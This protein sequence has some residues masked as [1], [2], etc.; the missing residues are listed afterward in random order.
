MKR[1]IISSLTAMVL[2]S[3]YRLGHPPM[4]SSWQPS[5]FLIGLRSAPPAKAEP[6]ALAAQAG[7]NT[8]VDYV[9]PDAL[10]LARRCG[11]KLM[12]AKIGLDPAT[13]RG[14]EGRR[15]AA[16]QVERFGRHP[17]LWGYFLGDEAREAD[18][19][20]L[21]R[22]ADS[23]RQHAK[24]KPFFVSLLPSD[25]FV[26]PALANADYVGYVERF[27]RAVRPPLLAYAYLPLRAGESEGGWFENLEIIRR[28]ALA[29]GIPFCA[30]LRGSVWPGMQPLGE[31][32]L[33][34]QVYTSLAYGAQGVAWFSYWGAPD[35]GR[36]GIVA[37]DGSPTERYRWIAALNA[38]LRTLGPTL[39]RLRSTAVYHT[40][41]VPPGATRLPVHGLVGAIEGG[42]F[43]VGLFD[44]G[45]RGERY[46]LLA[47]QER[48]REVTAKM[49]IHQP[50]RSAAWLDP[51]TGRWLDLAAR[52]DRFQT[53]IEFPLPAGGGRLLRLSLKP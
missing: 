33:R 27:L 18:F 5:E 50:C 48:Q 45:G 42:S 46:V 7:F 49:T 36:E 2:V 6:Y 12:V 37:P 17:A 22:I 13:F 53:A 52:T 44:E 21:G 3:C 25:A 28:A 35:G 9:G 16:G 31:G 30:T 10:D 34:W 41:D 1:A 4:A 38:E 40:G 14:A 29:Q 51:A 8:I 19:D 20:A 15:R 43:V 26:G 23:L 32:D 24:D 11:L 39:L 47:N